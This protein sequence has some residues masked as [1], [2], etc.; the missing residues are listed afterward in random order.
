MKFFLDHDVPHAVRLALERHGHEAM[1]VTD[2]LPRDAPDEV[3]FA[4]A[5]ENGRVMVTCNRNDFLALAATSP[6]PGLIILIRRH[7]STAECGRL[8]QLL[9]RA[10]EE[11]LRAN[12]NFA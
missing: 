3:V 1:Q 4:H 7:S 12:V 9:R 10:G 5:V 6:H 2:V 8:L 11:G